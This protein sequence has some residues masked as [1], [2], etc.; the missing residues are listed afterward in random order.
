MTVALH[1][2][3][4]LLA[5]HGAEQVGRCDLLREARVRLV[6]L[7]AQRAV[8]DFDAGVYRS[9][10]E[11]LIGGS[12]SPTQHPRIM[13][14]HEE[15]LPMPQYKGLLDELQVAQEANNVTRM[16][17]TIARLVPGYA[18]EGGVVD[19]LHEEQEPAGRVA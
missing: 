7:E 5:D 18:P 9:H 13:R 11:L 6:E 2:E 8:K 3:Q 19:P 1:V 14:A 16:R 4:R 10:L 17:E 12:P 15:F